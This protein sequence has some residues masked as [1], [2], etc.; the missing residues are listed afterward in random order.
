MNDD[1]NKEK[2]QNEII[3]SL[4]GRMAFPEDELKKLITSNSKK[5]DILLKAYNL[6]D[7]NTGLTEIARKA[8]ISQP[9]LTEAIKRWV[10]MGIVIKHVNKSN[11][12]FPQRLYK[13][14]GI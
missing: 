1:S 2:I 7:G 5:P 6:C 8:S 10:E 11:Q 13:L 3:I 9:S 14:R 4:L 12:V